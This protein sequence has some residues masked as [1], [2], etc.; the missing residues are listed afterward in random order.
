MTVPGL[1]D[2]N[3]RGRKAAGG[4]AL[5]NFNHLK[6]TWSLAS[7]LGPLQRQIILYLKGTF[8]SAALDTAFT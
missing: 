6:T 2:F 4:I 7:Y 3:K 5:P 1:R 8:F